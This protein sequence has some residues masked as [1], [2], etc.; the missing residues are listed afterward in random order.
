MVENIVRKG[1]IL[2]LS[3]TESICRQKV[4]AAQKIMCYIFEK[5]RSSKGI[6][7]NAG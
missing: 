5:A 3:K 6:R 2:N 1:E 7:G 4:N